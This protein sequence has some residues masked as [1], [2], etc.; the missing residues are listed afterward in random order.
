MSV[1]GRLSAFPVAGFPF[2]GLEI[3]GKYIQT[4]D[5]GCLLAG[6]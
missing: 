1:R 4:S 3:K 2:A 6:L 5:V